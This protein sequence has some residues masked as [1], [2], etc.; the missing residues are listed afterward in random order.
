MIVHLQAAPHES[1]PAVML[2]AW[3]RP[4]DL[5]H[6]P[7]GTG[8]AF[9]AVSVYLDNQGAHAV[10]RLQSIK[11]SPGSYR[12]PV[13]RIEPSHLTKALTANERRTAVA[14]ILDT[15]RATRAD[16]VQ[17]DFDATRSQRPFYAALLRDVSARLPQGVF[18]WITAL[19]S[20]CGADSWLRQLPVQEI[21]PMTFEMGRGAPA[22]ETMLRTGGT[23]ENPDCRSSVGVALE[24]ISHRPQQVRRTYVFSY[25]DW[26]RSLTSRV[27]GQ[28][29]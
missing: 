9:F 16:A 7:A 15:V 5:T 14:V 6:L 8:V 19:A 18:L 3:E 29:K 17:I 22:L 4:S 1:P 21:V 27:L 2:W 26:S 25:Q 24:Q 11:I 10:P 12:M 28:L 20:W 13:V 23:F